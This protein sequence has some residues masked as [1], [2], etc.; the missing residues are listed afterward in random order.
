MAAKDFFKE[1][2]PLIEWREEEMSL[3]E[4]VRSDSWERKGKEPPHGS[5]GSSEGR[6]DDALLMYQMIETLR[7]E[8]AELRKE[9]RE[10]NHCRMQEMDLLMTK[11]TALTVA[12]EDKKPPPEWSSSLGSPDPA[13]SGDKNLS[14]SDQTGSGME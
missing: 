14:R 9:M 2:D 7:K 11:L 10:N 1:L 6:N 5:L 4:K 13:P 3:M 8:N 12:Q